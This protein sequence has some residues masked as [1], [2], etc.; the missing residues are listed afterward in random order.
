MRTCV[1]CF[2]LTPSERRFPPAHTTLPRSCSPKRRASIHTLRGRGASVRWS[3]G[4]ASRAR[5]DKRSSDA[6]SIAVSIEPTPPTERAALYAR[7]AGLSERESELL[8][9][10]VAGSDT[11]ELAE[12]LFVSQHTVQDHLKSVFAKTG[13]NSRRALVA[14]DR[15][16]LGAQLSRFTSPHPQLGRVFAATPW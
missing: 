7:V 1:P 5:I 6:A 8:T 10:L 12:R 16:D 13:V 2:L 4:D 9:L 15:T 11:R 3:L 14:R